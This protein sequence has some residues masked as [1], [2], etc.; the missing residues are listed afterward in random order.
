MSA[1]LDHVSQ[2]HVDDYIVMVLMEPHLI[3]LMIYV[4]LKTCAVEVA[5]IFSGAKP[6]GAFVGRN[7]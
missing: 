7:T 5:T 4:S 1:F 6:C 2:C 3:G